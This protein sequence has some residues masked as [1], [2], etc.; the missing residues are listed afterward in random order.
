[1]AQAAPNQALFCPFCGA[2]R[3]NDERACPTCGGPSIKSVLADR[4]GIDA[5][6]FFGEDVETLLFDPSSGAY[7]VNPDKTRVKWQWLTAQVNQQFPFA[8][9]ANA[10]TQFRLRINPEVGM[11]GDTEVAAFMLTSTGRA[12]CQPYVP[13][14]DKQ[15]S[16]NLVPTSLM[17]GTAQ[18]QALLS[19]TIYALPSFDWT[20]DVQDLSGLANTI[21]AVAFGRRFLDSGEQKVQAARR[22]AGMSKFVH[23]YWLVPSSA[24]DNTAG[25]AI[26]L[27]AGATVAIPTNHNVTVT[28]TVPS[29][30]SF[31]C[32]YILDDSSTSRGAN[33]EI[34][35]LFAFIQESS[36]GRQL[37]DAPQG[38]NG[39]SWR[40]FIAS[41][42]VAVAG[43]PSGGANTATGGVRASSLPGPADGFT[44]LFT[45]GTDIV[46]TFVSTDS[47][48]V[49][50]RTA[51]VG[52]LVYASDPSK[53]CGAQ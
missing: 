32:R 51:F 25:A 14:L 23:P 47:G 29:D 50:L 8:L 44:H 42:T 12:A 4:A 2:K 43:F 48:T 27:G 20:L 38:S 9:G 45:P 33:T 40:A 19:S 36:G 39:L 21:S 22:A 6:T 3:P 16:N 30:A 53:E 28:Y 11:R 15:L 10:R 13:L 35:D 34:N 49:T 7:Y 17:F 26:V 37:V 24:F 46:V 41:P 31:D 52:L 18:L 1:M 5:L